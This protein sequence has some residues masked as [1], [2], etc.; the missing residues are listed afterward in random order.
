MSEFLN[1]RRTKATLWRVSGNDISGDQTYAAPISI[2]VRWEERTVVFTNSAG[3]DEMA[4]AILWTD[5]KLFEGEAVAKGTFTT[6][7]PWDG[8]VLDSNGNP[9]AREIQGFI[10]V[11]HLLT[12]QL[13][14]RAFLG[15]R[16]LR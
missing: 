2:L 11:P 13:E 3:Q 1:R 4:S 8:T 6:T 15:A 9:I 14:R 12:E 7:D 5:L 16:R 10:E